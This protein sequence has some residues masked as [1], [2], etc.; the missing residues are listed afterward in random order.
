MDLPDYHA[1]RNFLCQAFGQNYSDVIDAG[2]IAKVITEDFSE[3]VGTTIKTEGEQSDPFAFASIVPLCSGTDQESQRMLKKFF[4]KT[5]KDVQDKERLEKL[6]KEDKVSVL[7][8]ER[9]VNMPADVAPPLYKQLL[10]D[11]NN[12]VKE[13]VLLLLSWSVYHV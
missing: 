6:L 2:K 4:L 13:V 8:M 5:C 3:D 12:A 10:H 7:F 1:V 9:F 11:Y